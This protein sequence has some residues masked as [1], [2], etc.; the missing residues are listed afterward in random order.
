VRGRELERERGKTGEER[1]GRRGSRE[2]RNVRRGRHFWIK[3]RTGVQKWKVS[4]CHL[5]LT[6]FGFMSGR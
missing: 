1:E 3:N 6:V 5:P 4:H 2:G